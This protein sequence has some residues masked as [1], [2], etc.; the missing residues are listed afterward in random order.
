MDYERKGYTRLLSEIPSSFQQ[1]LTRFVRLFELALRF[2][3][4]ELHLPDLRLQHVQLLLH[5]ISLLI[6]SLWLQSTHT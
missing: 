4:P 3:T 6:H 2:P 5:T 1:L